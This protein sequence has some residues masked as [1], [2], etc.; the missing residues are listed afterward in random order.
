MS[1]STIGL[2]KVALK[3]NYEEVN[4]PHEY[5]SKSFKVKLSTK[6]IKNISLCDLDTNDD[7]CYMP[8]F[9]QNFNDLI[10]EI[11][12]KTKSDIIKSSPKTEDGKDK[13]NKSELAHVVDHSKIENMITVVQQKD[14]LKSL[15]NIE[16][17]KDF[18]DYTENCLKLIATLKRPRSKEIEDMKIDIPEKLTKKK[19]LAIFDLDETL[20][21]CE[22]K[23]IQS[24]DKQ[25]MV[26]MPSGKEVK[27]RN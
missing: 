21:H 17:I 18:Y 25:I 7:S 5:A 14:E 20:I 27:V 13:R 6:N 23:N 12:K 16:E 22:L 11:K 2:K 26:K 4:I 24:A 19:K 15:T 10:S 8:N 3:K 1:K 9:V